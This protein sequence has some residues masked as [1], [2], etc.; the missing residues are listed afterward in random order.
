[1]L[2]GLVVAALSGEGAFM[3]P[4]IIILIVAFVV[5]L[6]LGLLTIKLMRSYQS[7]KLLDGVN[8][9]EIRK[10]NLESLPVM[11]ELS[12]IEDIDRF[13]K[14]PDNSVGEFKYE[15]PEKL[16]LESLINAFTALMQKVSIKAEVV[17]EK[18]IVKDRFTVA[19]KISHIKWLISSWNIS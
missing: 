6:V 18:K 17:Q 3:V 15:L 19:Q 8:N 11:V 5:A 7:K 16:K 10:N 9:L 1:M 13:Y 12:K 14:A 2:N 4:V